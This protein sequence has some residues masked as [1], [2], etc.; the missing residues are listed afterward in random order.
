MNRDLVFDIH[1]IELINAAYAVVSQHKSTSFN[2]KLSCL[3]V[4]PHTGCQTCCVTC[5]AATVDSSSH[6]LAYVLEELTLSSGWVTNNADVDIASK[7]N[8]VRSLLFNPTEK[9]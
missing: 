5:L 9:L 7:I 2:A 6:E 4:L 3:G 8:L 1:F